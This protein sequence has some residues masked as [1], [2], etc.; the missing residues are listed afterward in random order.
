MRSDF[1]L[2]APFSVVSVSISSFFSVKITSRNIC[3]V[4]VRLS[5]GWHVGFFL[6]SRTCPSQG[7]G[8]GPLGTV[9]ISSLLQFVART[10]A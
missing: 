10:N 9:A 5:L 3:R 6:E 1:V 2:D 4:G 8:M 7:F